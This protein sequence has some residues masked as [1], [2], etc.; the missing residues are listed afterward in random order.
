MKVLYYLHN[1]QT[2]T[3]NMKLITTETNSPIFQTFKVDAFCFSMLGP[4]K[5]E[6]TLLQ[7]KLKILFLE[8]GEYFS[9]NMAL[10]MNVNL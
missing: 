2:P 6:Y 7:V 8:V 10:R 5:K 4:V 3:I 9:I 1:R